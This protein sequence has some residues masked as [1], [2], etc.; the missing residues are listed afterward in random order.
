[1]TSPGKVVFLFDVDNTL[2][3]N[4]RVLDDLRH[5]LENEFGSETRDRYFAISWKSCLLNLAMRTTWAPCTLPAR[6]HVRYST[7][8]DVFLGK[9]SRAAC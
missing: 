9:R 2:L 6:G 4:D 1:M 7:S 5:Y 8:D 3:D